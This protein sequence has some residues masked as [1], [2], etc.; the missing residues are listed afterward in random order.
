MKWNDGVTCNSNKA[1]TTQHKRQIQVARHNHVLQISCLSPE[2]ESLVQEQ[3]KKR[4]HNVSWKLLQQLWIF[5]LDME[6][7]E[8][9]VWLWQKN[10]I[11]NQPKKQ[12]HI[13]PV[14][15]SASQTV[16]HAVCEAASQRGCPS[17]HLFHHPSFIFQKHQKLLL[18]KE[19]GHKASWLVLFTKDSMNL[20]DCSYSS[21]THIHLGTRTC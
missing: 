10:D 21:H 2:A 12:F 20:H 15:Q 19:M 17:N 1:W 18:E 8:W 3:Q 4:H 7:W 13:H 9:R 14:S 5:I 6:M 16:S 11:A